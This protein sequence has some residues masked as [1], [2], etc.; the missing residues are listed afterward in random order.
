MNIIKNKDSKISFVGISLG[1]NSTIESAA[2]IID[3]SLKVITLEKLFSMNDVKYFLNNLAGKQ[4]AVILVSVPENEIMISSK[5]KYSSRTYHPINL[6]KQM[7]NRDNWTN[8]FSTRGSEYF[9]D[10][11][12]EGY[13]IY[14][15]DINNI[16][17]VFNNGFA[18][19]ER[20]PI[21]CKALQDTLRIKY[22]MRDLPVNMLPVA[23]LEAIL[24]ALLAKFSV[25][26]NS[27]FECKQIGE[28]ENLPIIGI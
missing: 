21:D 1:G 6:N 28:Y 4:N 25:S 10:L 23:Q 8:R 24:G 3:N 11:N 2:A 15:F 9:K 27:E 20:S 12:E 19:K 18:Y 17:K 5:W 14:R 16:K 13:D 22:N 26:D 7:M